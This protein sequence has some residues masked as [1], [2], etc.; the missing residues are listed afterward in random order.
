MSDSG[1]PSPELRPPLHGLRVLDCGTGT[2]GPRFTGLLADYGADVIWVEPPGGDPW[3]EQLRVEYSVYNRGK[4]SV[5]LD[6]KTD[7][8]RAQ[9][10]ELAAEADIVTHSFRPGVA[11][12][13]GIGWDDLHARFPALIYSH[14]SGFGEDSSLRDEQGYEALVQAAVGTMAEQVGHRDAPIYEA[15][16][17][18]SIGAAYLSAIGV[19]AGLY[20]RLEDGRGRKVETSLYDG[21]V[22]YLMLWGTRGEADAQGRAVVGNRRSVIRNFECGDGLYIAVHT[23]AVGGVSRLMKVLGIEDRFAL[24]ADGLDH[25]DL[26]SPEELEVLNNDIPEIFRSRPREHWVNALLEADVAVMPALQPCEAYD[27]PQTIHNDLIVKV[28]DPR[29]GRVEQVGIGIDFGRTPGHVRGPAPLA[30]ANQTATFLA[31]NRWIGNPATDAADRAPLLDGVKILDLGVY[32]AGP[33]SSRLLADL[34][35]DVI[36]LETLAGDPLRGRDNVFNS[37]QAGK[38]ALSVN[39]KTP[40]GKVILD[41]LLKWADV[42]H[43]NMRPGAA[44]RLQL[45]YEQVRALNPQTIYMHAPGWGAS[46]PFKDRQSFAPLLSVYVG[47]GFEVAGR[48]NPPLFPSGNEDTGNGYLG[49]FAMLCS[50]LHRRRD[51]EGQHIMNPQ[52]NAALLHTAHM[53]RRDDGTVLGAGRLDPLQY[54]ISAFDRLY[55]TADGWICIVAKTPAHL[56]GI[57]RAL[58]C[59]LPE[60]ADLLDAIEPSEA[61]AAT[62]DVLRDLLYALSTQQAL[63]LLRSEEVPVAEPVGPNNHTFMHDAENIQRRLVAVTRDRD[64]TVVHDIDLLVR[65]TDVDQPTHQLAPHLGEHTDEILIDLGYGPDDIANLRDQLIVV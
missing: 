65:I 40:E 38:R 11:E 43:H 56:R 41:S 50:L 24:R 49:A 35:A 3:R 18:A 39:L 26:A 28:D 1:H 47:I 9:F 45:G 52:L 29:L 51:G 21:A 22:S 12:R 42:V 33:F 8:G 30:G 7:E 20:R 57:E 34:G 59:S 53:V 58:S 16:P 60:G 25:R 19:L 5:V 4:R 14:I 61:D 48:F 63:E 62:A 32:Y 2:A 37:G 46:G 17:F 10:Y 64:G 23:G 31:G 13:L 27:E 15:L 44:E 36:K 6:L 54:G 55:E